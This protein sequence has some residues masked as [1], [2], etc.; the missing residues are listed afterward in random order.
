VNRS[1]AELPPAPVPTEHWVIAIG[2]GYGAFLFEGAEADAEEMRRHK[3][4]WEQAVGLK[5][6]ATAVEV[7]AARPS[8]CWNHPEFDHIKNA[9]AM[10]HCTCGDADCASLQSGGD[11]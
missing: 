7:Q 6:H 4:R 10:Y 11:Q 3:A 8:Q 1:T 9:R 5:R 2:G